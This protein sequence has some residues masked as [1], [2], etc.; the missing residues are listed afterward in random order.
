MVRLLVIAGLLAAV[1]PVQ[2]QSPVFDMHVH[3]R[4]G[5]ASA[6]AFEARQVDDGVDLGAYGAMWFGGPHQ[7]LEGQLE[8]VRTGNDRIIALAAANPKVLPIATVHPYDGEAALAELAR[9][10]GQGV[11]VLKIHPHTQRFDLADPRVLALARRA[12]ELGMVVLTDNAGIV[13]DDTEDLFNLALRAPD[14]QFVFAHIGGL[15]FRFWNVLAL[16]RTAEG[17]FAE[18]IHFDI[19]AIVVLMADAPIED[20]FVW[21]LRN[22]GIDRI[23]LGSDYPQ[24]SLADTVDALERLGLTPEETAKIRWGNAQRLFGLE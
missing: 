22:V 18:N 9:V 12:G 8:Q 17:V 1:L 24:L 7:A 3:L 2:A 14:T 6:G 20:E 21:T 10:A 19:S 4:D 15:D 11:K 23:L 5:A 13:A 16:A